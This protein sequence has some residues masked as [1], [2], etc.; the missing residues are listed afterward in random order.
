MQ[1]VEEKQTILIVDDYPGN[2]L[3]MQGILKDEYTL[4]TANNGKNALA[5]AQTGS[6][7]LI[8]L[9]IAMPEMDGFEVCQKLKA[10]PSTQDIPVIFITALDGA[11]DE[12][13]GLDIGAIDYIT[14]P[15][16]HATVMAR[17]RN[18]LE[19]LRLSRWNRWILNAAGEGLYGL[20]LNGLVTFVNPFAASMLGWEGTTLLG[21]SH[22]VFL[23][24]PDDET[25]VCEDCSIQAI[26][27]DGTLH[28]A[29]HVRLWRKDG[30]WFSAEYTISP[31]HEHGKLKGAVVVFRDITEHLHMAN[32]LHLSREKAESANRAKSEFLANMS[33]EIRTPMNAIIGLSDL[34]LR[35]RLPEK[36]ATI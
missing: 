19:R 10:L 15:F 28:H 6:V 29:K 21:Q 7:D 33:H 14:K 4:L 25:Y 36:H 11:L 24:A 9:D 12:Q 3:T 13:R 16:N 26:L 34:A 20:G 1:T 17:V 32:D 30:S 22:R 23:H 35:G 8:L 2:V 18:H 5:I 31:I 27:K